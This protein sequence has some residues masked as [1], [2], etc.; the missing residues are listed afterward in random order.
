MPSK[1][2]LSKYTSIMEGILVKYKVV[3]H[4]RHAQLASAQS[5]R[6]LLKMSRKILQL[7]LTLS[8]KVCYLANKEQTYL[9]SWSPAYEVASLDMLNDIYPY[10]QTNTSFTKWDF[11]SSNPTLP[12]PNQTFILY[13]FL[14]DI[15]QLV[16]P[17]DTFLCETYHQSSSRL[18][19]WKHKTVQTRMKKEANSMNMAPI[20]IRLACLRIAGMA[21]LPTT[22]APVRNFAASIQL[23]NK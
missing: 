17:I 19:W 20:S 9:T 14:F 18:A 16:P 10:K 3:K 5:L 7:L 13:Y 2:C 12:H 21:M 11:L 1:G 15:L 22:D 6:A 23:Q 4:R 8:K